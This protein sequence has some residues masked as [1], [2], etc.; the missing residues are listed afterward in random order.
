MNNS[1]SEATSVHF[2]PK[3]RG[4]S[5]AISTRGLCVI[6]PQI[7]RGKIVRIEQQTARRIDL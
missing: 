6:K 1:L 2:H 5:T 3:R 4:E 7:L